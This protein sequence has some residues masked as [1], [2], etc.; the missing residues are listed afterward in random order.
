MQTKP[1][2]LRCLIARL[3]RD[4][5]GLA[6]TEFAFAAPIMVSLAMFGMDTANYALVHLKVNQIALNLADN[7][8]RVGANSTLSTQ[9]MREVDVADILQAAATHGS[10]LDLSTNGRIILSSLERDSSGTQRLHWQRC[11]GSRTGATYESHYGKA[12]NA[13]GSTATGNTGPLAPNGM[14]DAGAK[15]NAPE[16]NSGVMFVEINYRYTPMFLWLS[17]PQDLRYTASFVVRDPRDFARLYPTSGVT[18]STCGYSSQV[19]P[20]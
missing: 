3:R 8:S 16:N 7:A 19:A 10:S 2:Q 1:M 17:A 11:F 14:G 15:V 18:S 9:Q 13:D 5:R 12:T 20:T 4:G 6:L